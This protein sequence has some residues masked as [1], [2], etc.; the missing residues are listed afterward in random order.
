MRVGSGK[1]K[2]AASANGARAEAVRRSGNVTGPLDRALHKVLVFRFF[3]PGPGGS[4]APR[5]AP[6]ALRG[7]SPGPPGA[8]GT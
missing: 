8:S 7:P 4:G 6:R 1:E 3:N 2:A 5:E